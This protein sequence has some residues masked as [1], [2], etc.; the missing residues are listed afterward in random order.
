MSRV[1]VTGALHYD[2]LLRA[3]HLPG[4]DE[5]VIGT[6]VS[7]RLGGKGANQAVAAARHGATTAM[8]GRLGADEAAAHM[9]QALVGAGVDTS[10]IQRDAG[11]SGMSAAIVQADGTYGAVIVS[12]ANLSL[13]SAQIVVPP[14]TGVVL[15]QNEVPWAVNHAVATAAQEAGARVVLNAAPARPADP[16]LTP[17]A[18]L[19]VVNRVEAAQM[20]SMPVDSLQAA[21]EAAGQ[22]ARTTPTIITLGGEGLIHAAGGRVDHYPAFAVQPHSTH[23]AGDVFVGAF[24]ARCALGHPDAEALGYA[25]AAAALHVAAEDP[26]TVT[27]QAVLDLLA[28]PG[29]C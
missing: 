22:L 4:V 5:T 21:T 17:L 9:R 2:I 18:D 23:G 1:F 14:G 19:L 15:L 3:P 24:A 16:L 27:S 10:Q 28:T 12:A 8:A 25:Q 11:P 29:V 20:A 6:H 7:Y 13:D 26:S